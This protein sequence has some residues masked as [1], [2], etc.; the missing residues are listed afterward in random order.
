MT[1]MQ[2][3]TK[4]AL[5]FSVL[6]AA[7]VIFGMVVA[8]S[9]EL[10]PRVRGPARNV[11]SARPRPRRLAPPVLCRHRRRG[12]ALG[13]LDHVDRHR[14]GP[15]GRNRMSPFG[16]DGGGDPFEFFFG[17][18]R[19]AASPR[20]RGRGAQGAA[21]RHRFRH[22]RR[23]RDRDE[24]PRRSTAPTRSR[25]ASGRDRYTAKVVGRDPAT[26]LALLK[27]DVQAAADAAPAR[28][29]RPAPRRR[30]GDGDRRSAQLRQDRHGRRRLGQGP[31][32]PDGRRRDPLLR[33]L[34]P[35]G[36]RDQLRQLRRAAASTSRGEVVGINTAMYRPAQN[37]G[38]AVPV[39][40]L[41]EVLPQLREQGQ[42]RPRLPRHQHPER[43]RATRP[44]P[45]S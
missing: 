15:S 19:G 45:S 31:L 16:G 21:G 34:H 23:R 22:L 41:K 8:G 33:E 14:Q 35:D 17:P 40:T 12:D 13:R 9:V 6:I 42:G 44:R 3:S 20:R 26:D 43:G 25:S 1:R 30:V 5:S 7:A 4:R 24:Q 18:R 10:T 27:I 11:R 28:R 2:K 38:F 32:G 36:R 39:N 37:I 29:L